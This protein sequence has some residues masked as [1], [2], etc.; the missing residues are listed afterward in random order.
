MVA[1][2]VRVSVRASDPEL[3]S[4][5]LLPEGCADGSTFLDDYAGFALSVDGQDAHWDLVYCGDP[6]HC[7]LS[8]VGVVEGR[9]AEPEGAYG[10]RLIDYPF[11]PDCAWYVRQCQGL[12][13]GRLSGACTSY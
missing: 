12:F 4:G 6:D 8:G 13:Q 10:R 9:V 5:F 11:Q 7:E 1:Y 2:A 3:V